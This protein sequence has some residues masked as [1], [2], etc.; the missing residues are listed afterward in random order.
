MPHLD[1]IST[2]EQILA[3]STT[4]VVL[5]T[6]HARP[7]VLRRAL[8][9]GV[10]AFASKST[11]ASLLAAIVHDVAAGGRYIDSTVAAAALSADAC[12]LT[13]RELDVLRE[14]RRGL[15]AREIGEALHLSRGTVRNY[16]SS[17]MAKIGAADRGDAADRAWSEGWI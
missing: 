13:S 8:A 7:G 1:G 14:V 10:S 17:A 12:P 16:L 6:R 4:K 15:R 2:A 3:Q 9:V 5:V 11:S